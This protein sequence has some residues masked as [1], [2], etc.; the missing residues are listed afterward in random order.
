[1]EC[2]SASQKENPIGGTKIL[3]C[4]CGLKYLHSKEVP[5]LKPTLILSGLMRAIKTIASN[6]TYSWSWLLN[7][8]CYILFGSKA[9]KVPRK[10]PLSTFL[11]QTPWEESKLLWT[12]KQVRRAAPSF[13]YWS[14]PSPRVL[15][16]LQ[17]DL[18]KDQLLSLRLAQRWHFTSLLKS[19]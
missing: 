18:K 14:T 6:T 5:I 16:I 15:V 12:P 10:L 9:F 17:V 3:F 7:I 19:I 13:L 1:M 11:G 4:G 8:S 2:L